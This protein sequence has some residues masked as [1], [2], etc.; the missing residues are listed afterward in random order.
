MAHDPDFDLKLDPLNT[1][2]IGEDLSDVSS[3]AGSI[4]YQLNE[5][6]SAKLAMIH[7]ARVLLADAEQKLTMYQVKVANGT[8]K[9]DSASAKQK[10]LTGLKREVQKAEI[11]LNTLINS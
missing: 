1:A 9:K 2:F 6:Y 10:K 11:W 4:D 5:S 7:S 3:D 8:A